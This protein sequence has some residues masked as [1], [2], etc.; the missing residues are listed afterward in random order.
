[1]KALCPLEE[2]S[3]SFVHHVASPHAV[4]WKR[5]TCGSILASGGG[6]VVYAVPLGSSG[7]PRD[8][9]GAC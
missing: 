8:A 6:T 5:G 4:L 7:T 3:S 2:M 1:M 9:F